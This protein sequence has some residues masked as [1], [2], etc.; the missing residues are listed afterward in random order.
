M[1]DILLLKLDWQAVKPSP[2]I[3]SN[4]HFIFILEYYYNST[5]S[6]VKFFEQRGSMNALNHSEQ[7]LCTW[8][9][10]QVVP[11]KTCHCVSPEQWFNAFFSASSIIFLH[12]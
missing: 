8:C 10:L 12:D 9:H 2:I 4:I 5:H 6:I 1:Q 3:I 7:E 11:G